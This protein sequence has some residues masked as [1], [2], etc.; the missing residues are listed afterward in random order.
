MVFQVNHF[1]N[2]NVLQTD[3]CSSE[4]ECESIQNYLQAAEFNNTTK[5]T[6]SVQSP[7]LKWKK[8]LKSSDQSSD[9]EQLSKGISTFAVTTAGNECIC[10]GASFS[11]I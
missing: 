2:D 1:G 9:Q 11:N 3:S 10:K 5:H 7:R 6:A 8:S 4:R